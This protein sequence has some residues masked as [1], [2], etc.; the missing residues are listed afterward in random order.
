MEEPENHK[1]ITVTCVEESYWNCA[2]I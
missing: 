2:A 1:R